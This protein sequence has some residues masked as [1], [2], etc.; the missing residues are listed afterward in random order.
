MPIGDIFEL[1]VDQSI[2]ANSFV[3]CHHFKQLDNDGPVDMRLEMTNA[4]NTDVIPDQQLIQGTDV[5]IDG[6]R[7]RR[8]SPIETQ[9]LTNP[10][11]VAGLRVGETMTANIAAQV[12]WYS[13]PASPVRVGRTWISGIVEED[14]FQGLLIDAARTL[15]INFIDILAADITGPN[16]VNFRKVLYKALDETAEEV[17]TGQPRS[18][19]KK[20][21]SRTIGV[22][23]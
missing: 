15:L 1:C 16:A 10:L 6:L 11:S 7:V 3:N 13:E 4:F 17:L 5:T 9:T 8:V 22:G 23:Q 12:A 20:L 14:V 19:T 2:G 18:P 21:A